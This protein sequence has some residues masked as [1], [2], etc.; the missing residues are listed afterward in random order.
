MHVVSRENKTPDSNARSKTLNQNQNK[1]PTGM[2]GPGGA[3]W[4]PGGCIARSGYRPRW[5]YR[6]PS[7]HVGIL[8][9]Q[10]SA[11]ALA[12]V[13]GP[14]WCGGRGWDRQGW[15]GIRAQ[16]AHTASQA[17]TWVC[18]AYVHMVCRLLGISN[19]GTM[20]GSK[21]SRTSAE[22]GRGRRVKV[23]HSKYEWWWVQCETMRT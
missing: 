11:C 10:R 12:D 17:R 22:G 6:A 4:R 8:R 19:R 1:V 23:C 5:M 14:Q 13:D 21:I 16:G 7:V 9:A 3:M 2:R 18:R 15:R 20:H